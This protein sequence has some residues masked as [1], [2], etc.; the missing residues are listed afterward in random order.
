VNSTVAFHLRFAKAL[1][2][3]FTLMFASL[4]I[5]LTPI[6]LDI[7]GEELVYAREFID[8]SASFREM[9]EGQVERI[10][11][12]AH[13]DVAIGRFFPKVRLIG[14]RLPREEPPFIPYLERAN[15]LMGNVLLDSDV[16]ISYVAFRYDSDSNYLSYLW[17]PYELEGTEVLISANLLLVMNGLCDYVPETNVKGKLYEYMEQAKH[18]AKSNRIGI[19]S[20]DE[21]PET[22]LE[23][24][25][26][27]SE[28]K[29]SNR[30]LSITVT[31]DFD[32]AYSGYIDI[33]RSYPNTKIRQEIRGT[34]PHVHVIELDESWD[35]QYFSLTASIV[36]KTKN[37]DLT[38]T[39]R[40][41]NEVLTSGSIGPYTGGRVFIYL[42]LVKYSLD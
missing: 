22:S 15:T 29:T 31:G 14:V 37:K 39:V 41:N 11:D 27:T 42:M 10:D 38:A 30:T 8:L 13:M 4:A 24:R 40:F 34:I 33:Q 25:I 1:L 20:E 2:I 6:V 7:S 16:F 12:A 19:W 23:A 36:P 3:V 28:K 5:S 9:E 32:T 21:N 26:H 35:N 17:F 18:N